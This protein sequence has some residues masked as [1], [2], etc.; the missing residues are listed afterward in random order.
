MGGRCITDAPSGAPVAD[1]LHFATG[2]IGCLLPLVGG[3]A[4]ASA[5]WAGRPESLDTNGRWSGLVE[6]LR[7]MMVGGYNVPLLLLALYLFWATFSAS[8]QWADRVAV[9]AGEDGLHF[10]WTLLRRRHVPWTEVRDVRR[11][12]ARRQWVDVQE[13]VFVLAHRQVVVRAFHDE[14]GETD[15]FLGH[16]RGRLRPRG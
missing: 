15:S 4:V 9:R 6:A 3:C 7:P 10:H 11:R 1:T 16:V 5:W 2:R 12:V 8:M 14:R 13:I